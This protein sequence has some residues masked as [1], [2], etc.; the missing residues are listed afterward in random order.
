MKLGSYIFHCKRTVVDD[1]VSYSDPIRY[2]LRFNFLTIMP[3][4]VALNNMS[5]FYTTEEYGEHTA[6]GWNG[7]A[8]AEIFRGQFKPGD[9][10]FLEGALPS[11]KEKGANAIITSVRDQNRVIYLTIKEIEGAQLGY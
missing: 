9:V 3:A 6:L 7:I 1:V 10:L 11:N 4:T 5:G 8:N 2:K